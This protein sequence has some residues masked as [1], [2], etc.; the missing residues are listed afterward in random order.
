M[1][2]QRGTR[3]KEDNSRRRVQF[4]K[5]RKFDGKTANKCPTGRNHVQRQTEMLR[6][7]RRN[8]PKKMGNKG[9]PRQ[10]ILTFRPQQGSWVRRMRLRAALPSCLEPVLSVPL[11]RSSVSEAPLGPKETPAALLVSLGWMGGGVC[12]VL[13]RWDT[14]AANQTEGGCP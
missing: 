10:Y 14:L 2:N 11:P 5:P 7:R 4:T 9:E 12:G 6:R 8:I 3:P 13:G 1:A